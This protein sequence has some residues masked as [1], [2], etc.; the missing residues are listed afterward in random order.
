M[1][2]Y[3]S[4]KVTI[5]TP[6]LNEVIIGAVVQYHGLSDSIMS[7]CGSVFT[8]KFWSSLCYFFGIKWKLSTVFHCQTDGQT[9]RQ[10]SII[11]AY[12]QAFVNYEQDNWT[13]LLLMA[14]FAYNNTKNASTRHTLFE[15]NC[16]YLP[17]VSY[18]ED[19]NPRSLSKS[20][21]KL[22]TKLIEL[23]IVCRENLQH[24]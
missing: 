19:V 2:H 1:I 14:E 12:L 24:T 20:A 5:D 15:L 13:Q 3:K 18:K 23:M 8:L 10:N 17:R 21:D 4:V 6:G 7:D 11:E 16:G 9:E 22:A